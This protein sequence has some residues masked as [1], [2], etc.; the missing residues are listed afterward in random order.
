MAAKILLVDDEPLVLG[1]YERTLHRDFQ[2]DTAVGGELGMQAIHERGP[3]AVVI[4]DMRMPGMSG[5]QFLAKARKASPDTVRMLLTGY[6]DLGAAMEAVNEGNIFRF[7]TKPCAK[8]VLVAAI[9]AGVEQYQL[10]RS[11]KELLE[12]TL[13][14][15]IKVLADILNVSSPEAHGRSMRIAHFV[16]HIANKFSFESRW[17]LEAAATLSQLGCV[18]LE[19][20]LIQRAFAGVKLSQEDQARFDTHPGAA[21]RLLAGIPRLE[22]IAWI[23]GQQLVKEIPAQVPELPPDSMQETVLSAT[24]LKLAVAFDDLR[25]NPFSDE[26][27]IARLRGRSKEFSREL[28]DSLTGIKLEAGRMQAR[29][30]PTLKLTTGMILDQEIRNKQGMLLFAKG[31]EITGAVLIKIENFAKASQIDLEV[32]VLVA[33]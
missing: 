22:P 29:R 10:I 4:S 28:I 15:S 8:E 2:V 26:E 31:Q 11:E 25:M 21:M 30:V 7:L 16:R 12:K 14:G 27:A 17:R 13:L 23:I 33:M 32:M 1:G 3:Y 9:N 19:A 5:A 20:D 6:T 18:T 24:I